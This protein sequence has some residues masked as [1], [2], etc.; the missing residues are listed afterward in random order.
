MVY[1]RLSAGEIKLVPP[2]VLYDNRMLSNPSPEF[3]EA[4]NWKPVIFVLQPDAE[5]SVMNWF[6]ET[7]AIVQ[8]WSL[9]AGSSVQELTPP[10]SS[11][12]E[13]EPTE[14]T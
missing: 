9:P 1:G 4:N 10:S 14:S 3:L 11:D 5:H 2:S 12:Q 6:E 7:N 13:P 8:V